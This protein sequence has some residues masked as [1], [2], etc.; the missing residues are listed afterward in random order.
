MRFEKL[1]DISLDLVGNNGLGIL[2]TGHRSFFESGGA[3][4]V[5]KS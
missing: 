1:L 3:S 5:A 2:P 4:L